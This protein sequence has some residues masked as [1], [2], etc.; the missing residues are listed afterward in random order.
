[1]NVGDTGYV[2][3]SESEQGQFPTGAGD[4]GYGAVN[5]LAIIVDE[6]LGP[7]YLVAFIQSATYALD[8]LALL[9][10]L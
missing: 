3:A 8:M 6:E 10:L 9:R 4:L 1:V 2:F 7:S 5:V